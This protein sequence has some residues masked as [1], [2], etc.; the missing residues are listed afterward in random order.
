MLG[1]TYCTQMFETTTIIDDYVL[2]YSLLVKINPNSI[3]FHFGNEDFLQC[4]STT[5]II[6]ISL[7]VS[8]AVIEYPLH[9]CN[10]ESN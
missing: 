5:Y 9:I 10:E 1:L 2:S 8:F 3:F 6:C 4:C 7:I